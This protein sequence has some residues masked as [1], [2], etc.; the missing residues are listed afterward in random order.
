MFPHTLLHL[1]KTK[2]FIFSLFPLSRDT[3]MTSLGLSPLLLRSL[4][5]LHVH[6]S[7]QLED[8]KIPPSLCTGHP[9]IP[10]SPGVHGSPGQPGRDGR[11]GRDAAPGERGDKG[12]RG[13]SGAL[14]SSLMCVFVSV[15]IV[16]VRAPLPLQVRQE[17]GAWP[18]TKVTWEKRGRGA[19]KESVLWL[20]NQ[21]SVP[22]YPRASLCPSLWE[23]RSASTRSRWTNRGT[24]T[25]RPDASPAKCLESTTLPS[26]PQ[27]T[28]PA[29]SSTWW[30]T[31]TRWRLTFSSTE[32]GPNRALCRAA[33]CSTSSLVTRCGSRWLCQSTMGFT[34]APRPT[35]PSRASWS[36]QNGNTLLCLHDTCL[37][38]KQ[39]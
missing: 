10:G 2:T 19:S 5:I 27:C 12:G 13:D 33:P 34:P 38:T 24:T 23:M 22:N 3:A 25:R 18:E 37:W 30:R 29:C 31:D 4:L 6:L 14:S 32:T 39:S 9:G 1:C 8:N 7:S 26:T 21:P 11:D 28:A 36:T 17:C 16:H 35:A 15:Q 20:P